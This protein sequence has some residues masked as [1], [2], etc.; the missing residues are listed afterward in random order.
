MEIWAILG[1]FIILGVANCQDTIHREPSGEFTVT[2]QSYNRSR[3]MVEKGRQIMVQVEKLRLERGS[4]LKLQDGQ[5]GDAYEYKMYGSQ[6]YRSSRYGG[7]QRTDLPM[8]METVTRKLFITLSGRGEVS[9]KYTS[10]VDDGVTTCLKSDAEELYED[11]LSIDCGSDEL[12]PVASQCEVTLQCSNGLYQQ[13]SRTLTCQDGHWEGN[14]QCQP[15]ESVIE[16]Q[17]SFDSDEFEAE[18]SCPYSDE[19]IIDYYVDVDGVDPYEPGL[20]RGNSKGINCSPLCATNRV[21]K[22]IISCSTRHYSFRALNRRAR[23]RRYI[24]CRICRMKRGCGG[25]GKVG[26]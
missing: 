19:E 14:V 2:S 12:S 8:R 23:K 13:Y 9:V 1:L 22:P 21:G 6:A 5:Y 16:D 24:R 4:Y 17:C 15:M 10:Y 3:I 18:D 20:G 11:A 25:P 26:F 7:L